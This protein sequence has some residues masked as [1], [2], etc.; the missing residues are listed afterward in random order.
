MHFVIN[1][2]SCLFEVDRV[3]SFIVTICFIAVKISCWSSVSTE[4]EKQI[5]I[6]LGSLDEPLHCSGD[7]GSCW[8]SHGILL[9]VCEDDHIVPCEIISVMHEFRHITDI[10]DTAS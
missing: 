10:V 7:I 5:V 2:H 6:W 8:M 3:D 1:D 4:M 9:V